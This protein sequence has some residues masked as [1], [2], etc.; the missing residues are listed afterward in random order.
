L[1]GKVVK[2]LALSGIL[3]IVPPLVRPENLAPGHLVDA[4]IYSCRSRYYVL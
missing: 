4:S 1:E 2:A 3:S